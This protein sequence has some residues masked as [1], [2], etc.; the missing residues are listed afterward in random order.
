MEME[1]HAFLTSALDGDDSSAS[2]PG[3]IISEIRVPVLRVVTGE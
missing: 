1:L 3:R 2:R